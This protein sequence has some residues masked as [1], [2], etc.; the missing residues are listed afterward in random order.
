M[1]FSKNLTHTHTRASQNPDLLVHCE[2]VNDVDVAC[3]AGGQ[4]GRHAVAVLLHGRS[5]L[6]QHPHNLQAARLG[7]VMKRRVACEQITNHG[8][9]RVTLDD[10][11]IRLIQDF[12]S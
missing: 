1:H 11:Q 5:K 9:E 6:Q 3:D 7:T 10:L 2:V 4:Q 8:D 12:T